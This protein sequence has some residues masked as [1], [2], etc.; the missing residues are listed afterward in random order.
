MI[1][2]VGEGSMHIR[3]TIVAA[4]AS[5]CFTGTGFGERG[6]AFSIEQKLTASD[7]AQ[8]DQFGIRVAIS[9]DTALVG[10]Y[11]DDDN[12][13]YSG[14][15]YIYQRQADGSWSEMQKLTASDGAAENY[16]GKSVSISGDTALVGAYADDDNGVYS[17]SAYIYERQADG[18]WS[19]MQKLTASDGAQIDQFGSSVAISGDTA[20]VGALADDD[21]GI[22]SGSAYIYERQG[23][24]S[25]SE[26]AK[27]TGSDGQVWDYFGVGVAISGDIA[28]VGASR[29]GAYLYE[30]QAD[31]NWSETAKLTPSDGAANVFNGS[32]AISGDTALV[33]ADGDDNGTDSGSAYIYQRQADG[34]WSE[35]SK[36]LASDGATYDYFGSSVAISG[37][38]A[39][40][41]AYS[42][43]DNGTNAGSAY[44][45]E[46]QADGSW[47][48][49]AKLT[50]SDGAA[51]DYF[52]VGVAIS[53]DTALVGAVYD[54]DNGD[55][56]GSAYL[57]GP[58]A[59]PPPATG[60]CCVHTGCEILTIEQCSN[61]GGVYMAGESCEEC[62]PVCLADINGDGT[63]DVIDLL[64]VIAAWGDCP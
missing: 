39:L 60:A 58:P 22:Y 38:T 2:P 35:T 15:A 53:G 27:L 48:E 23:D 25:W 33:G 42:N 16:F 17:G 63:V 7:G 32:V 28:L 12:G 44:I 45:Y 20:L 19:E 34:T 40:V 26:V 54:E 46:R 3:T 14:S 59:P 31:G 52:G 30:R 6:G 49:T 55:G 57:F 11:G 47:S 1:V 4:I 37:E 13:S 41:G 43:D 51:G 21:N 18:S 56:S 8:I 64:G 50:A 5:L 36:L 24:G 9:G 29:S 61:M 62:D 10:A